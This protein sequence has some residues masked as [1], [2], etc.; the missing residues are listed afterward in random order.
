MAARKKRYICAVVDCGKPFMSA[1]PNARYCSYSCRGRGADQSPKQ[2]VPCVE[3]GTGIHTRR[4]DRKYC[5]DECR[6]AAAKR[7]PRPYHP[8]AKRRRTRDPDQSRGRV[9]A[10]RCR[11]CRS[12]LL[13]GERVYCDACVEADATLSTSTGHPQGL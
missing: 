2:V 8:A 6:R 9:N 4:T 13:P 1:W 10:I 5:S 11:D 7:R 12:M 3:C